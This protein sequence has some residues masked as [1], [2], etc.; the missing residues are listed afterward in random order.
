M[1]PGLKGEDGARIVVETDTDLINS[2]KALEDLGTRQAIDAAEQLGYLD[3]GSLPRSLSS[4]MSH[5]IVYSLLL[6]KTY[7]ST[8]DVRSAAAQTIE[9]FESHLPVS[10]D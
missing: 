6:G 9:D 3:I 1:R 7:G 10:V 5:L 8:K 2:I 4:D